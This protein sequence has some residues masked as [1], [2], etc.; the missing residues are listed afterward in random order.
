M[1][2]DGGGDALRGLGDGVRLSLGALQ[3]R[4]ADIG[5]VRIDVADTGQGLAPEER[6]RIFTPYYT[7]KEHGTGLGLSICRRILEDHKGWIAARSEPG[8]GAVFSFG[9]PL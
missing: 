9:L 1:P 7:T 2:G 3:K 6:D 8:R 4:I 5:A